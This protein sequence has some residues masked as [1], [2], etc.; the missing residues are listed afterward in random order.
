MCL[1]WFAYLSALAVV[2]DC[3]L[4]PVNELLV[5]W[6]SREWQFP[7]LEGLEAE[8]QAALVV[9]V[10][11]WPLQEMETSSG[12]IVCPLAYSSHCKQEWSSLSDRE[13]PNLSLCWVFSLCPSAPP[14]MCERAFLCVWSCTDAGESTRA[15]TQALVVA[16]SPGRGWWVGLN[17]PLS[18]I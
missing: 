6:L 18:K 7:P 3:L 16:A 17:P 4:S 14:W 13:F 11:Y 5:S 15:P 10:L 8:A 12:P 1:S 2:P 9:F